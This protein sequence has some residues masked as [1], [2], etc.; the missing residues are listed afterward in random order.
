[1]ADELEVFEWGEASNTSE[2]LTAKCH[3]RRKREERHFIA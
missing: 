1:M 2:Q 3:G